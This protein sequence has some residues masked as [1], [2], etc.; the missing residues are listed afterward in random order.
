M[1]KKTITYTDYDDNERTETFMFNL[2]KAEVMEMEVSASGGLSK[3]LQ[4]LV[5][6]QDI[7]R[8]MIIFKELILKS[9]GVKS[10]DGKHFVKSEELS[11]AFCQTE[12]YSVFFT[13]LM[14]DTNVA[15]AFINGIVPQKK[16]EEAYPL[17]KLNN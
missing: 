4:R 12:A 9:Y 8:I 17:A 7:P 3:M 14:N 10:P 15:I 1:I 2:S 13:E 16:V 5:E 6:E 11:T